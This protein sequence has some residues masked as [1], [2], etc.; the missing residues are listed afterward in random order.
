MAA[1]KQRGLHLCANCKKDNEE[2]LKRYAGRY[3]YIP[4]FF[5]RVGRK[6]ID[7]EEIVRLRKEK[8]MGFDKIAASTN[9]TIRTVVRKLKEEGLL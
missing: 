7:V 5:T 3:A 8:G 1:K 9:T 4:A 2:F 6:T